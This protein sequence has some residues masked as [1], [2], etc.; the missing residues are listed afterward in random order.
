MHRDTTNIC[1]LEFEEVLERWVGDAA[2]AQTAFLGLRLTAKETDQNH[3]FGRPLKQRSGVRET[4]F[5]STYEAWFPPPAPH[6]QIP[7]MGL[8]KCLQGGLLEHRTCPGLRTIATGTK[9]HKKNGLAR[10]TSW[11]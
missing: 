8:S 4:S 10:L 2:G 7:Q 1:G 5:P 9:S 11:S 6:K 3:A